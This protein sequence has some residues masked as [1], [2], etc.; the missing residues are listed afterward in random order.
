MS[1]SDEFSALSGELQYGYYDDG[2]ELD[3]VCV[4]RHGFEIGLRSDRI[5]S[6]FF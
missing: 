3:G 5:G 4:D 1:G 6:G 2:G